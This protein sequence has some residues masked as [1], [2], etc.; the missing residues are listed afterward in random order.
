[1]G[2]AMTQEEQQAAFDAAVERATS[3][4]LATWEQLIRNR[5]ASPPIACAAAI[6][7]TL[8]V[9]QGLQELKPEIA[10]VMMAGLIEQLRR[11][12]EDK[13]DVTQH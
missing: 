2:E 13:P 12:L 3:R 6:A 11:R 9:L 7:L 1:M 4:L 5:E 10:R 8:D